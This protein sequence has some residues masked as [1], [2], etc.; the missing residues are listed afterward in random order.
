MNSDV[1]STPGVLSFFSLDESSSAAPS[2]GGVG[3][4]AGAARR[5]VEGLALESKEREREREGDS[6]IT[7]TS[8][9]RGRDER[10]REMRD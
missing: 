2:L 9:E 4:T 10:L 8:E 5:G 1:Y 3:G 7:N 6:D